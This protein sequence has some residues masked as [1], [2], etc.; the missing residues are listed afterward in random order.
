MGGDKR[1]NLLRDLKPKP[2]DRGLL[3]LYTDVLNHRKSEAVCTKCCF[4]LHV[5]LSFVGLLVCFETR[6]LLG[7][8][9]Y[10]PELGFLKC[11]TV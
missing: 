7:S 9:V 1:V 3:S 5:F 2:S 10:G 8:P 6:V 11:T 4:S